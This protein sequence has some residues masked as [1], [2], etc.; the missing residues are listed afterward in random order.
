[1]FQIICNTKL[2]LSL[3]F[4]SYLFGEFLRHMRPVVGQLNLFPEKM[5]LHNY[6]MISSVLESL[7]GSVHFSD[8]TPDELVERPNPR[9]AP[10]LTEPFSQNQMQSRFIINQKGEN[11]FFKLKLP[12][13]KIQ[14]DNFNIN[15]CKW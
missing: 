2:F 14:S 9:H 12:E 5:V 7:E 4:Y 8:A 3:Y 13:D 10:H 15:T 1:M 6:L 11:L